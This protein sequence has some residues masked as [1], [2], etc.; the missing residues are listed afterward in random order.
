[1]RTGSH[2]GKT[3]PR[4]RYRGGGL[5]AAFHA[6]QVNDAVGVGV[7]AAGTAAIGRHLQRQLVAGV[8]G[9]LNMQ[10]IGRLENAVTGT[11]IR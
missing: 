2:H 10:E 6:I 9:G 7:F 4:D 3:G 8:G 11:G 5:I 1:V